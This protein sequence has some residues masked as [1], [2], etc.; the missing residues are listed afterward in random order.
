M[1]VS[2]VI[3]RSLS[4]RAQAFVSVRVSRVCHGSDLIE[5]FNNTAAI[6]SKER[7]A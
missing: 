3:H 6:D 4:E 7:R 1:Y 2:A 5:S